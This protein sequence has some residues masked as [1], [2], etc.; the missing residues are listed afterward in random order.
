VIHI[1]KV[2]LKRNDQYQKWIPISKDRNF[3]S[4][5]RIHIPENLNVIG[6]NEVIADEDGEVHFETSTFRF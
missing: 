2:P 3:K 1:L 6:F 4:E 5:W